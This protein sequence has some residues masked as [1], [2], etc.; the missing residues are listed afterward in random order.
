ME[1]NNIEK[2]NDLVLF[3][4][5]KY[6]GESLKNIEETTE[7]DALRNMVQTLYSTSFVPVMTSYFDYTYNKTI[8]PLPME[9]NGQMIDDYH[10]KFR[11]LAIQF[12]NSLKESLFNRFSFE[13]SPY[14]KAVLLNV[15]GKEFIINERFEVFNKDNEFVDNSGVYNVY[16]PI[17]A[18]KGTEEVTLPGDAIIINDLTYVLDDHVNEYKKTI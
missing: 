12:N 14:S 15:D 2:V 7:Y 17:D 5:L 6:A 8:S 1:I 18:I 11:R 3:N 9:V 13:E 10:N 4:W 16:L